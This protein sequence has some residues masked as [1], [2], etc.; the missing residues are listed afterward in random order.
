MESRGLLMREF[1]ILRG[2]RADILDHFPRMRIYGSR[3]PRLVI[4]SEAYEGLHR[5]ILHSVAFNRPT[6]GKAKHFRPEL[7]NGRVPERS[8]FHRVCA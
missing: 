6:T 5:Q 7:G 3:G 8:G 4:R 1:I 2:S